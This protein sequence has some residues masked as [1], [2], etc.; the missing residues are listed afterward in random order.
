MNSHSWHD[1]H[2][3]RAGKS[4]LRALYITIGTFL[5]VFVLFHIGNA[6]YVSHIATKSTEFFQVGKV[7]E[8]TYLKEQGDAVAQNGLIREY[9][10]AKNYG[11]LLKLLQEERES[12]SIG[13]MG[14]ADEQGVIVSRTLSSGVRGDNVFLTSPIGRVVAQGKSAESVELTS[15]VNQLFMTTGRPVMHDEKMIG[16]LFANYLT[17]DS[18][19]VRFR[20]RYLPENVEIVFY[21][22]EFGVYGDSFRDE[23]KRSLIE[24]YFNVGSAWV[25]NGAS[26]QTISFNEDTAYFVRNIVFPGLEKSPGG[27][28]LFIPRVDASRAVNVASAVITL[29]AFLLLAFGYHFRTRGEERGWHYF[30]LLFFASVPVFGLAYFALFSQNAGIIE[31]KRVPYPLYNSMMHLHP[32]AGIFDVDFERAFTVHVHPGDEIINVVQFKLNFDPNMVEVTK[33]DTSKSA[34]TYIVENTIDLNNGTAALTCGIV[35]DAAHQT[36]LVIADVIA[37]PRKVGNFSLSFDRAESKVLAAD[38]LGTDVL[39]MSQSGSYVAENF[40]V[41][42][43]SEPL[44]VFSPTNPNQGRWYNNRKAR[45][46]WRGEPD[47]VYN[48]KFDSSPN[49]IPS[50]SQTVTGSSVEVT[51]PSDGVFYFHLMPTLG[52]SVAHYRVQSD[53]TPPSIVSMRVSAEQIMVGDVVRFDFEAEDSASGIQKNYYVDLGNHLFLP[54]GPGIFVPFL[55]A[56]DQKIV[57]RVYDDADN[58]SEKSQAIHVKAP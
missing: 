34:C 57:L 27:A 10:I 6:L 15:F 11:E 4:L 46:V 44:V 30:C 33:I 40:D 13:L 31:L 17:D 47:T 12:R 19:A 38:G 32:E 28:L 55:E 29:L 14:I 7:T 26:D 24:S 21:T 16:G 58:Y 3:L 2:I 35:Q 49:T 42:L 5:T 20:D 41:S 8:L 1:P 43:R 54:A 22:K 45:F 39:R 37:T 48:Y 18:Y 9:L 25:Q 51:I 52:G 53:R 36:D 50:T 23:E 56:G